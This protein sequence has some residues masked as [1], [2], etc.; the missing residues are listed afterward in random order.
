M[1][2]VHAYRRTKP[3]TVEYGGKKFKFLP[4]EEGRQ[5]C[6]VPEGAALD[7]LVSLKEGYVLFGQP[8]PAE[9]SDSSEGGASPY[10][11]T[12]E[13]DNDQEVTVDLLTLTKAELLKFATDN[14]VEPLPA[15]NLN[16]QQIADAIVAF[17]K[18]E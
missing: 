16:K 2:L 10:V 12:M 17:F 8:K 4:D 3:H 15:G 5:V 13:G 7:R 6:D 1:P 18:V 14:E 11:L 9:V